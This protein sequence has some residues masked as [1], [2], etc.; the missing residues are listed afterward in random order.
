MSGIHSRFGPDCLLRSCP[1]VPCILGLDKTFN[2]KVFPGYG[3]FYQTKMP[4]KGHFS[5]DLVK[6]TFLYLNL[7]FCPPKKLCVK[8]RVRLRGGF[9]RLKWEVFEKWSLDFPICPVSRFLSKL[10]TDPF[11]PTDPSICYWHGGGRKEGGRLWDTHMV[12]CKKLYLHLYHMRC[13]APACL[14]VPLVRWTES[15]LKDNGSAYLHVTATE[16]P[17]MQLLRRNNVNTTFHCQT[18]SHLHIN[19]IVFNVNIQHTAMTAAKHSLW[20]TTK[21]RVV[22]FQCNFSHFLIWKW[23]CD[24]EDWKLKQADLRS[25]AIMVSGAPASESL[26]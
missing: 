7:I 3:E 12:S 22:H 16:N 26:E 18:S 1:A 21:M 24:I 6:L 4:L 23:K 13:L 20:E 14:S 8:V 15:V 11:A 17:S 5:F 9:C 10:S 19:T 25:K 2:P